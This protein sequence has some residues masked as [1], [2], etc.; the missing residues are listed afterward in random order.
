MESFVQNRVY[1]LKYTSLVYSLVQRKGR[2]V[3]EEVWRVD[4]R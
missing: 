2:D 1:G 4:R 3:N